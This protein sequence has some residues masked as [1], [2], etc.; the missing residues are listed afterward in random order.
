MKKVFIGQAE[1][2][3]PFVQRAKK[4]PHLSQKAEE[5]DGVETGGE[6]GTEVTLVHSKR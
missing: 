5:C 1:V 4:G 3:V 2:H 6:E